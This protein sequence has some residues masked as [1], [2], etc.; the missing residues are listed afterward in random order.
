MH[1]LQKVWTEKG[2]PTFTPGAPELGK[3]A[4]LLPGVQIGSMRCALAGRDIDAL[5]NG[6]VKIFLYG[7]ADYDTVFPGWTR[8][9]A[10][11]CFEVG[12]VGET[13]PGIR[14]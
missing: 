5:K 11:V 9:H 2:I 7:R 4:P 8:K 6:K 12:Y 14:S 13:S 10:E 1:I 3:S